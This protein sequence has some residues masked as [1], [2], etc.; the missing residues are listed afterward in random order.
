MH[1]FPP[2]HARLIAQGQQ[3]IAQEIAAALG[4]ILHRLRTRLFGR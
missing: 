4:R 1:L 3:E 2:D